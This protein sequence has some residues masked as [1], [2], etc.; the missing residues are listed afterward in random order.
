MREFKDSKNGT[1]EIALPFGAVAR[2]KNASEGKFDLLEPMKDSLAERLNRNFGEFWEMLWHLVEPQA[3]AKG[4]GAEQFGELMAADC[5][6]DAHAKFFKEWADFFHGLQR[7]EVAIA[8]EMMATINA[9]AIQELN[10]RTK[11]ETKGL[12]EHAE[13]KIAEVLNKEFGKLRELLG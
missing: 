12:E 5:I 3:R 7:K 4:I 1:W 2:V 13:K 11:Q 9:K 10:A 8:L 6:H